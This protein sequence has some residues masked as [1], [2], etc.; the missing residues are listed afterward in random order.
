MFFR[1]ISKISLVYTYFSLS[2]I[3]LSS[4]L[5]T[6]PLLHL[7]EPVKLRSYLEYNMQ[8]TCKPLSYSQAKQLLHTKFRKI[9]IYGDNEG[10]KNV[11][12][13]FPQSYFKKDERRITMKSDLHN[14]YLCNMKLNSYRQNFKYVDSNQT[15]ENDKIR[16]LDMKGNH[17]TNQTELFAKRGY[18]MITNKNSKTFIPSE[19]SRGKI[20]RSLSYFAIKYDYLNQLEQVIDI[21]TL[22]EWNLK[23]PVDNEEYLNNIITYKHQGDLNPFIVDP[24]LVLYC[25][26]DKC[27]IDY[28]LML[29]KRTSSV[30]PLYSIDYLLSEIETLETENKQIKMFLMKKWGMK[31]PLEKQ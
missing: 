24:D 4:S 10:E 29:K 7:C 25:F 23:D 14:L 28:N 18:L 22:L 26:S 13:I 19:C 9:D 2:N 20:A 8:K 11:E 17:I 5:F 31:F 6:N 21:S 1:K 16:V 15:K 27:T 3:V 12:H 30:D